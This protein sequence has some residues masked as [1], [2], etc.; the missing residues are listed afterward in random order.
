MFTS[1]KCGVPIVDV[2]YYPFHWVTGFD[3]EGR[4]RQV[5]A[6]LLDPTRFVGW[7]PTRCAI[8][9]NESF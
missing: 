1:T 8:D 3:V 5:K 2:H 4:P 6:A 9:G 7:E